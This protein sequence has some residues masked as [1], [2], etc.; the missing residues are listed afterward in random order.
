MAL[1]DTL[2]FPL[3][4]LLTFL[5][6]AVIRQLLKGPRG[7]ALTFAILI[8]CLLAGTSE[9]AQTQFSRSASWRDFRFDLVGVAVAAAVICVRWQRNSPFFHRWLGALAVFG[10]A[11]ALVVAHPA[12]R[13]SKAQDRLKS[14][15]PQLGDFED[16]WESL[17][18]IA[19]GDNGHHPITTATRSSSNPSRGKYSLKVDSGG[20]TW[21]G[22]RLL[23]D[24]R[25]SWKGHGALHFDL[26]NPADGFELGVRIDGF[27]SERFSGSVRVAPG[28]NHCRLLFSELKDQDRTIAD[29]DQFEAE[30]VILHLG[31]T[32][33]KRSFYLDNVR[34]E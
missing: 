8:A 12:W 32:P 26:F 1:Q 14:A 15:F 24:T 28:S 20:A 11:A 3:F 5:I 22:V 16:E 2:H 25:L 23:L 10:C 29:L 7:R 34:L 33:A 27:D 13:A 31:K 18:W 9:L 21:A 4:A 19:Q 30:K 17:L 6:Y